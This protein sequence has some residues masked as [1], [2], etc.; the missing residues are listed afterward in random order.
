MITPRS[1]ISLILCSVVSVSAQQISS[2]TSTSTFNNVGLEVSLSAA[3]AAGST[4]TAAYCSVKEPQ[5]WHECHPFA[6][7]VTN[8]FSGSIFGLDAGSKYVVRIR[9]SFTTGDRFDT[10]TTRTDLFPVSSGTVY[11]VAKTGSDANNG[12]S[13][14]N[15][16]ASLTH[17]LTVAQAGATILLHGGH[18][19]ESVTIPR[20]GTQ[21]NPICIRNAPGEAA[22]LDGRDTAFKPS[23]AL[24]NQTANI[25]RTACTKQ[26]Q[27]AYLNGQHLFCSPSLNDLVSNT[28]WMPSGYFCDGQWMYIQPP[29]SGSPAVSDTITIPAFT[30]GIT[31]T[32]RQYI[33]VRG[34]EICYYGLDEYSRGIYLDGSSNNLIDSCFLHHSGIGVAFKRAS[35]SNTIQNCRFTESPIDTWVWSAVKEGTGYYE[36]GGVVVYG[37]STVSSGN[38]VRNN[39]FFHMFDGSH[40]YS[41]DDAGPTSNLDFYNNLVEYIN[42]DCI[43][44]DGAGT[45]CRI[46][47]NTFRSFLSGV[48]VA[49]AA[50]G[51]TWIVRNLF[52]AWETHDG[53]VGY[54]VKFN[55]DAD[56]GTYWVYMYHNT[57]YTNVP[58]QP[59]FLFK[60]YS[61]WHNVFSR[62]NIFAG[63]D[64]ALQSRSDQNPVDFDYDALYTSSSGRLI[65]W[66]NAKYTTIATFSGATG[67]EKHAVTGN[68]LF[69]NSQTGDFRLQESSLLIDKG[70]VIPNINDNF[71][72]KGPDIGKFETGSSDTKISGK[73]HQP[74]IIFIKHKMCGSITI[75]IYG[76]H[77][78]E[79]LKLEIFRLDG[80][81][82][83][84]GVLPYGKDIIEVPTRMFPSGI[85]CVSIKNS[86][87]EFRDFFSI[88]K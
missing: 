8:R 50:I 40:L 27:F 22:V 29:H 41:E 80:K 59:G 26:P 13:L 82:V 32:G 79:P 67:Q 47:N 51:P 81:N 55:V 88:M 56:L 12:T 58:G 24:Y 38:V 76:L 45:N 21:T 25:Y 11:H 78:L 70:V 86:Q 63:T 23:W 14:S 3:P 31:C 39:H 83:F 4:I 53:Y 68:P 49:P 33:Q 1:F 15:A 19:Y 62:N 69:V 30:T 43:E 73:Q 7:T 74:E 66:A 2:V 34:L 46:Y 54:P 57:C 6:Q 61:D 84:S 9:T 16:F 35:N 65:D 36:A 18:Y 60:D 20:S 77:T 85:F 64:Y 17:A 87:T 75:H 10:V 72:G 28:W 5:D 48:S 37:S 42:D 44:T 52:T 71:T